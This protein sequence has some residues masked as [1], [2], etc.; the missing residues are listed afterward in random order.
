MVVA[1]AP[2]RFA[3]KARTWEGV[4]YVWRFHHKKQP[5][6]KNRAAGCTGMGGDSGGDG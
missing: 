4:L 5:K 2:Q 6:K 1:G 3:R